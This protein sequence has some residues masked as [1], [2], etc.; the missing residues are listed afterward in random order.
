MCEVDEVEEEPVVKWLRID[1]I[2]EGAPDM[3][4]TD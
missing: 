1:L 3:M 4:R 2:R